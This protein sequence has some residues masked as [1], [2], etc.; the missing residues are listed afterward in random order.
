MLDIESLTEVELLEAMQELGETGLIEL[1]K[2]AKS[3]E[4]VD[5]MRAAVRRNYQDKSNT[6]FMEDLEKIVHHIGG[7]ENKTADEM[8]GLAVADAMLYAVGVVLGEEPYEAEGV[9]EKLKGLYDWYRVAKRSDH[10]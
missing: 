5:L 9:Q 2:I 3:H 8:F 1:Y 6:A 10:V 4:A 7:I